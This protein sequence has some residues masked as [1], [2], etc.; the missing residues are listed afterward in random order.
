[1]TTLRHAVQ[2]YVRLRRDLGFK[3]QE[4]GKALPD[5]VRFMKRHRGVWWATASQ[6]ADHWIAREKA[7]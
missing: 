7:T 3:L 6:V 5:F 4:A 2:E 1:M